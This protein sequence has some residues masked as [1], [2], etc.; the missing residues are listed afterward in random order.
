MYRRKFELKWLVLLVAFCL[1]DKTIGQEQPK[2]DLI[3]KSKEPLDPNR[4]QEFRGNAYLFED[5]AKANIYSNDGYVFEDVITNYNALENE[6]EIKFDDQIQTLDKRHYSRIEVLNSKNPENIH[7]EVG[8]KTILQRG[9]HPDQFLGYF[10][11]LYNSPT[12][13]L[14]KSKEVRKEVRTINDYGKNIDIN[15]LV[16]TLKYY[17]IVD[18]ASNLVRLKK[19]SLI[20]QLD[21][22][23]E[24]EKFVKKN[25]LKIKN[26]ET[27][28]QLLEYY[29][30]LKGS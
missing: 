12:V 26:E 29:T 8:D 5:W 2:K 10:V 18:G 1:A 13:T 19:S 22:Q 28:I 23:S 7:S 24:L 30:S 14:L 9:I 16:E 3:I 17:L 25:K 6:V 15:F 27:A 21:N 20:D 4:Y 11:L